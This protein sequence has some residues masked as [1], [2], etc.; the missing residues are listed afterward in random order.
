MGSLDVRTARS[1]IFAL[2]ICAAFAEPSAAQIPEPRTTEP[3]S[4]EPRPPEPPNFPWRGHLAHGD[5]AALDAFV[6]ANPTHPDAI[7]ARALTAWARG[8]ETPARDALAADAAAG[9]RDAA[10]EVGLIYLRLGRRDDARAAFESLSAALKKR[11]L[12]M[13]EVEYD[14]LLEK[15]LI[16]LALVS[17]DIRART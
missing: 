13:P 10:L 17:R 1:L 16:D 8:D 4:S 5:R 12:M 6:T 9:N 2:G 11:R 15:L 3:Q 14:G 7:V